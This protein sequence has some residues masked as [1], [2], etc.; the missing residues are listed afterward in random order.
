MSTN[1][2][3]SERVKLEKE[4]L[5]RQKQSRKAKGLDTSDDESSGDESDGDG[6]D[7]KVID[8]E[9]A[10]MR[11]VFRKWTQKAGIEEKL[12]DELRAGECEADWTRAVAPKL[13]GRIVIVGEAKA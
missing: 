2:F 5:E 6:E 8:K 4:R 7:V 9:L 12:C 1:S 11:R 10:V 3:L 13:E